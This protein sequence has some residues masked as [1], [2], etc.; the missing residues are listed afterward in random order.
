MRKPCVAGNWKMNM[1]AAEARELVSAMLPQLQAVTAV[2]RVICPPATAVSTVAE[3]LKGTGIGLGTQNMHWE[4]KGAFTGELS[5]NM[6]KEFCQYVILGH[7]ERREYFC[8]TDESV[9]KKIVAALAHG[10][11]PIVCVGETLE[12]QE[13]G[14]T[15]QVITREI[16]EGLRIFER[17]C[18]KTDHCL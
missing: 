3:I 7:S 8:E 11:T 1:T 13:S 2:E 5:P 16:N 17:R 14:K 15:S 9:N 4:E 12:E 10:L 6:V 18:F